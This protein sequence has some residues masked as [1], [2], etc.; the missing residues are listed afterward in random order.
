MY[1]KE[2]AKDL[3]RLIRD[4]EHNDDL[5]IEQ[6]RFLDRILK[7]G[8][9]GTIATRFVASCEHEVNFHISLSPS[10]IHG[11]VDSQ[12]TSTVYILTLHNDR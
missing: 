5:I 6:V 8:N 3:A 4:Q 12:D 1:S 9:A 10:N 7:T 2:M 11:V